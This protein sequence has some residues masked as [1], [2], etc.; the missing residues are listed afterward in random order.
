MI[1]LVL[2]GKSKLKEKEKDQWLPV[3]VIERR[4]WLQR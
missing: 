2:L 3:D 4:G 1:S